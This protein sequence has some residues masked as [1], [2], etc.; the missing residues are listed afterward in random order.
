MISQDQ[1]LTG[2]IKIF[3]EKNI[4][5]ISGASG[6]GKTTFTLQLISDF[7]TRINIH[8]GSCIW[9]Q[10]CE[11]FPINRLKSM[12][13]VSSEEYEFLSQKIFTIPKNRICGS[14]I[15]QETIIQNITQGYSTLPP[16][17][18]VIVIDNIS[19]HL[20]Y[21]ILKIQEIDK[22]IDTQNCFFDTLLFPLVMFCEREQIN[23]ILIHEI[24]YNPDSNKNNAFFHKLYDRIDCMNIFL[25]KNL[26]TDESTM[27]ISFND[28]HHT[29][30]YSLKDKGFIW[31]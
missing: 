3:N 4:I 9:V 2:L 13:K 10:A 31:K 7:L 21:E 6:T 1:I 25:E 28:F 17:L 15:E 8:R 5:S 18:K 11:L 19:R 26:F 14:Y 27:N 23:L 24:S 16:D 29:I 12:F 20:R 30:K 22:V